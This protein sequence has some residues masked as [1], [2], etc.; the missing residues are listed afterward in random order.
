[1]LEARAPLISVV[2]P[3]H[4]PRWLEGCHRALRDQTFRDFEW[5]ITP[6]G[7][8]VDFRA[9][10]SDL[11]V[12]VSRLEARTGSIGAIKDYAFRA[13][14]GQY[15]L[16]LDHD[17]VL[18]PR[19]LE[20]VADVIETER[21]DFVYSDCVDWSPACAPVTYHHPEIREGWRANG[22]RFDAA[23]SGPI[24]R[25]G[26]SSPYPLSWEPSAAALSLIFYAPNHLRCWRREFYAQIGGHNPEREVCDDHELLVRTYLHGSMRR[27][28]EPL[29]WYRVTGQNSWQHAGQ[30]RIRW[31]SEEI[32]ARYLHQLVTREMTLKGLPCLDL[33]GRLNSPGAPWRTVD[34]H[35]GDIVCDLEE[36]WPFE[37][38]SVGAF[39][40]FDLLEHL[41]NKLHTMHEIHRCLV[42]GGWLLSLTPC[43]LGAGAYRDP[44][45]VSFWVEDSFRYYTSDLRRFLPPTHQRER[46]FESQI[47][48]VEHEGLPYV[49]ADIYKYD[50]SLPGLRQ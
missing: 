4:N 49:R 36:R 18:D 45:H 43:A 38:N 5:C 25:I 13:S 50:E 7:A 39:R 46:F 23:D 44:T 24:Y 29:Y 8:A 14:T 40:A 48:T 34:Q 3:T 6:N 15:V 12:R 30:E 1:M 2:T 37:D 22:W 28:A 10:W 41:P 11:P 47:D 27:I 16:E 33:G 17:D 26:E 35:D 21:P 32:R 42:P 31:H 20:R 19:A 9:P